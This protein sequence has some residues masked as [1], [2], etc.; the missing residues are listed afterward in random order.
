MATTY[1]EGIVY[2]A[3]CLTSGKIYIGKTSY[4]LS[5]RKS[6]HKWEALNNVSNGM[7]FHKAIRKY[8]WDDFKWE[9]IFSSE[10][11]EEV[12]QAEYELIAELQAVEFG[13]NIAKGGEGVGRVHPRTVAQRERVARCKELGVWRLPESIEKGRQKKIGVRRTEEHKETMS[14]ARTKNFYQ[15]TSPE[16]AVYVVNSLQKACDYFGLKYHSMTNAIKREST[17]FGWRGVKV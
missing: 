2:M 12:H 13:Y 15:I 16:G 14:K 11:P 4:N 17:L 10:D 9:T 8:G 7:I 3:T 1:L 6:Q 5:T